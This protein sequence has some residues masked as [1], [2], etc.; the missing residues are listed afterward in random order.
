MKILKN[1][2]LP[3]I[4]FFL[5]VGTACED[6]TVVVPVLVTEEIIYNSGERLRFLG[7]IITTQNINADDHGFYVSENENFTQPIVISLGQRENPGRFIGET[8]GLAIQKSYFIKAFIDVG[9]QIQFGNV[10]T[11]QTLSPEAL[12]LQPNN[13]KAGLIINIFGKNFTSDTKVFFGN[14]PATVLGIDFESRIRVRVPPAQGVRAVPVRIVSQGKELVLARPFEY[15]T[16]TYVKIGNFPFADR[17]FDNIQLQEGGT[18][19]VGLGTL[20]AQAFNR[21]IWKYEVGNGQWTEVPFA[22]NP[23]WMSFSSDRYFGSGASEL[24]RAPYVLSRDFWMLNSGRFQKLPDLPFEVAN[25]SSFELNGNLYVVGG[26]TG[27]TFETYKYTPATG[28]WARILNAPFSINKSYTRFTY[29]NKAYFINPENRQVFAFDA[30]AESWNLVTTFPASYGNGGGFG[31]VIGDRAYIGLENRTDQIWELDLPTLNW[32]QKN[33]FT[34]TLNSRNAGVFAHNGL[35]YILRSGEI[36]NTG[37]M[38]LYLF[39]PNGL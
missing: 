18:F 3:M 1:G 28:Q 19:Y 35:I 29:K 30:I 6:E 15:T 26:I 38:E 9:G 32:A 23:L 24:G 13:G 33:D 31:V 5:G 10:L 11:T 27:F 8:S 12:D 17:F 4:L 2:I 37:P 39:D 7:R 22:G 21:T 34:G 25:A 36:L 14:T 20:R 16:G